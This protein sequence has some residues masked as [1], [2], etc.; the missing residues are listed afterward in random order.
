MARVLFVTMIS[1]MTSAVV[2]PGA[3][4]SCEPFDA[5][6]PSHLREA[7]HTDLGESGPSVDDKIVGVRVLNDDNGNPIGSVYWVGHVNSVDSSGVSDSR[8]LTF[9]MVF[10][11]GAL[12]AVLDAGHRHE[13]AKHAEQSGLAPSGAVTAD[14]IGGTKAYAGARGTVAQEG[15]GN[16]VSYHFDLSCG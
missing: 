14:I 15:D 4:A 5:H 1:L 11:D 9:V 6:A 7:H 10:N 13:H 3:F 16:D 12:F 8:S 2:A